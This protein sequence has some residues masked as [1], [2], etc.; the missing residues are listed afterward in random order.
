M[1]LSDILTI[2]FGIISIIGT[3]AAFYFER[4]ARKLAIE[5][6]RFSWSDIE[7]GSQLITQ[8]CIK[9]FKPKALLTFSGS[10]SVIGN[11]CLIYSGEY[12][13]MYTV[14]EYPNDRKKIIE[15]M[16]G[17]AKFE[18]SKW[19]LFVPEAFMTHKN[20]RVVLIH[21]C[22]ISG[23]GLNFIVQKL[24]ESGFDRNN[25]MTA[26]LISTQASIDARL[27]PDCYSYQ[28]ENNVFYFPWG[29]RV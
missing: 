21:D 29:K 3:A 26:A 25:I 4:R 12:L 13:P 20:D 5:K 18:Y 24:V 7:H 10:G 1:S 28:I 17:F 2:L 27:A 6:N 23:V 19:V 11:L 9:R 8:K 15:D 16:S 14:I 22:T